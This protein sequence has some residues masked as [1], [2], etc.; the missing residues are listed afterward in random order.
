M[1]LIKRYDTLAC[2]LLSE[3]E[4]ILVNTN[5]NTEKKDDNKKENSENTKRD[6]KVDEVVELIIFT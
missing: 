5:T 4:V 1:P 2:E 6:M 3:E